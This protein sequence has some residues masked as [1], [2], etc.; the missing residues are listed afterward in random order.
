MVALPGRSHKPAPCRAT[1]LRAGRSSKLAST[2]D[3]SYRSDRGP[4]EIRARGQPMRAL[5]FICCC[6]APIRGTACESGPRYRSQDRLTSTDRQ[7]IQR[8]P[9]LPGWSFL[10]ARHQ[11]QGCVLP[12]SRLAMVGYNGHACLYLTTYPV[13]TGSGSV[14][15]LRCTDGRNPVHLGD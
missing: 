3:P 7:S 6:V 14:G 10:L 2:Y 11:G 9:L 8:R 5:A 15:A 1:R 4:G 13:S 12:W